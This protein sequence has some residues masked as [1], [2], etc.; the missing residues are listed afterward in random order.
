MKKRI[1]N[2]KLVASTNPK[3]QEMICKINDK[4]N[5]QKVMSVGTRVGRN[6]YANLECSKITKSKTVEAGVFPCITNKVRAEEKIV[7]KLIRHGIKYNN[8]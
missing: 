3:R 7:I 5:V 4:R 2:I 6:A 8:R 1:S